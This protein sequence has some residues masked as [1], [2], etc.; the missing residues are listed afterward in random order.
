MHDE[1]VHNVYRSSQIIRLMKSWTAHV[2]AMGAMKKQL[3][4]QADFF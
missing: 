4:R 1:E 2:A 3:F